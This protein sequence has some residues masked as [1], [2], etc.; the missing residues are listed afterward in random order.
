M[1]QAVIKL[2][3]EYDHKLMRMEQKRYSEHGTFIL[4]KEAVDELK[5]S[6]R[7]LVIA[8]YFMKV[9][10]AKLYKQLNYSKRGYYNA[11]SRVLHYIENKL[12]TNRSCC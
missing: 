1:I 11:Q 3:D 9:R 10:G 12:Q 5:G 4:I 8:K 7:Q 2:I 6:S